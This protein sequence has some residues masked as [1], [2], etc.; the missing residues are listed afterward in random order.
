MAV[1]NF[2]N[3]A[4]SRSASRLKEIG[5]RKTLGS[6]QHQLVSMLFLI[7]SI[8]IS[9]MAVFLGIG[10][11]IWFKPVFENILNSPLASLKQYTP[12][13]FFLFPM[14]LIV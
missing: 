5:V 10:I 2:I 8:M 3:L 12:F 7:E 6:A 14:A 11:A 13:I 4:L 1:V 9:V